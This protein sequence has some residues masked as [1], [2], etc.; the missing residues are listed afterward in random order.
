[1]AQ[2]AYLLARGKKIDPMLWVSF[3]LVVGLGGATVYFH[4]ENFIK[5]K[6]TGLYWAM[7]GALAIGQVFFNKNFIKTLMGAQMALPDAVW[8]TVCWTW[9]GFFAFMGAL[10][11]W[12]AFNFSTDTWVNFKMF[13]GL[14]LMLVFVLAQ[15]AY[16]SRYAKEDEPEVLPPTQPR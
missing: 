6:P 15:A 11:L 3:V 14:G 12:V 5:W 16:L 9:V 13:G 4:N 7:G 1:V 10:N 8:R 2:I